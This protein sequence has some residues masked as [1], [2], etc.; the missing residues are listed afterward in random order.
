MKIILFSIVL[1]AVTC[2]LSVNAIGNVAKRIFLDHG[3]HIM[4]V[5]KF[6]AIAVFLTTHVYPEWSITFLIERI[7][8]LKLV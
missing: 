1:F 6:Y 7:L 8:Q 5:E 4:H 3:G 2:C